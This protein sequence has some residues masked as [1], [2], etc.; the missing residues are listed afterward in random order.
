M[1]G[2]EEKKVEAEV[3]WDLQLA[4]PNPDVMNVH[5]TQMEQEGGN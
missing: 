2:V 3:A 5:E 1:K 4:H